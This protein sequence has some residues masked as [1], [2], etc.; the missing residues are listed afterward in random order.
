MSCVHIASAESPWERQMDD[1]KNCMPGS[2]T[3][4]YGVKTFPWPDWSHGNL[5]R[6]AL[7]SCN[8]HGG[9]K[10]AAR[11]VRKPRVRQNANDGRMAVRAK[12]TPPEPVRSVE[13]H[14]LAGPRHCHH[15]TDHV[16]LV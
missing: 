2:K 13:R 16:S 11:N 3:F 1:A 15:S 8:A 10:Y 14:G 6:A 5:H 4:S 12:R 9:C 7:R